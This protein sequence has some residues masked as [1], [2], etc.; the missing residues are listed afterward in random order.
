M[1]H[2][3]GPLTAGEAWARDELLRLRRDRLAPRA[4]GRFLLA[5]QRR[6]NAVRRERPELARQAWSWVAAGAVA[7]LAP[8][9][10]GREPFRRR[11]RAGLGWWALCGLML[12]WH[13]GMVET[14]QGR[15]R[16]L[17]PADAA[18]LLRAWLVPV[19]ADAP[20]P[21]VCAL[22]A[23]SDALDGPLARLT[24]PTRI[25]RDFEGLA[26]AC[27]ALAALR[28]ARAR[29]WLGPWAVLAELLRVSAGVGYAVVVY[30]ARASAPDRQLMHAGRL[31]APL[32]AAGLL[33]AGFRR[34]PLADALV[35]AGSALGLVTV[36]RPLRRGE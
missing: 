24:E 35:S 5:S 17:G 11:L 26:D 27:F 19:A 13:L 29:D 3:R 31:T 12:D 23:A 4:L 21:A 20:T 25:G 2:D 1:T 9:A 34:R 22:A 30:F 6:A 7:W 10:A 15:P 32:R 18:T 33:A 14:E 16:R 28:G 36:I 8:A